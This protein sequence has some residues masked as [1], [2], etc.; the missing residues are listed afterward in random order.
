VQLLG[1]GFLR[2]P[3]TVDTPRA[4][5]VRFVVVA[6]ATLMA[7]LLYLDRYC[8]AIL[9][10][11]IKEDL[12]LTESQLAWYLSIF[13]YT[14]ALAQV[15][16]GWLTDRYG[17]RIMLTIYILGWSLFAGLTGVVYGFATLLI[18]RALFG[19]MQAGAYPTAAS[20]LSKWVPLQSRGTA[21]GIVSFGGR[22]GGAVVRPPHHAALH[23]RQHMSRM[24]V[25]LPPPLDV[26]H[27][28]GKAPLKPLAQMRKRLR[29]PRRR[30]ADEVEADRTGLCFE[31]NGEWHGSGH[32]RM[33]SSP[34]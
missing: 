6:L 19:T 16:S 7:S 23:R 33:G 21:S 27:L 10:R 15:P 34:D 5:R 29:R 18:V 11:F 22:I 28:A 3:D 14:Y 30:D 31:I 24:L 9:E 13:F 20:L 32:G 25:R 4:S 26:R 1:S 2:M 17:A 12:Q 8:I